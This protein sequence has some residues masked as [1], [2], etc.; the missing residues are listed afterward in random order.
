LLGVLAFIDSRP[1]A[2]N[3]PAPIERAVAEFQSA[4]RADPANG[5][6]KFNLEL[7]LRLLQTGKVRTSATQATS[8]LGPERQGAAQSPPGHGY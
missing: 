1:A 6:A 5:D 2:G 7:L 4:V 8:G 3:T